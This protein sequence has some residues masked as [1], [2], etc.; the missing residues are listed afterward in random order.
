MPFKKVDRRKNAPQNDPLRKRTEHEVDHPEIK[1]ALDV[2][3]I[4]VRRDHDNRKHLHH[5]LVLH[6]LQDFKAVH[7]RHDQIEDHDIQL[8]RVPHHVIARVFAVIDLY[9][10]HFIT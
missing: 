7:S 9:D 10:L 5:V 2:V 3:L 1:G 8:R 4:V 6:E